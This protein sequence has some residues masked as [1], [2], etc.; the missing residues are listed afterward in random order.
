MEKTITWTVTLASLFT[1]KEWDRI[2][3]YK[4]ESPLNVCLQNQGTDTLFLSTL[5]EWYPLFQLTPTEN[6]SLLVMY[7]ERVWIRWTNW[8]LWILIV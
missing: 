4:G 6:I 2:H 8:K 3:D 1:D 7:P 5:L